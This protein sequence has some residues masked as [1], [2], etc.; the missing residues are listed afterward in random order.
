METIQ[1]V[2]RE[3]KGGLDVDSVLVEADFD[4]VEMFDGKEVI[5]TGEIVEVTNDSEEISTGM[6]GR[7]MKTFTIKLK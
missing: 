4:T 5:V 7:V 1:G 3:C 6:E 2:A